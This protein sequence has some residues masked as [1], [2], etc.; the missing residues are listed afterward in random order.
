[1]AATSSRGWRGPCRA[2]GGSGRSSDCS[3]RSGAST[4]SREREEPS[5]AT[6]GCVPDINRI[7]AGNGNLVAAGEHRLTTGR[8]PSRPGDDRSGFDDCRRSHSIARLS[9]AAA[10]A[11]FFEGRHEGAK[12]RRRKEPLSTSRPAAMRLLFE[13][14][15]GA[16]DSSLRPA[17]GKPGGT[18][19]AGTRARSNQFCRRRRHASGR[20]AASPPNQDFVGI[21]YA[22]G[23]GRRVNGDYGLTRICAAR[24]GLKISEWTEVH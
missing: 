7:S 23:L 5:D 16:R 19:N 9:S 20:F 8:G 3:D 13:I 4:A 18:G 22:P 11:G 1:V 17:S 15:A 6:L 24:G 10:G 12:A 21:D 2:C 14:R